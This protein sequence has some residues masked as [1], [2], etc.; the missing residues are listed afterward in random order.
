MSL[1]QHV[2]KINAD[3]KLLE[4]MI[5][6]TVEATHSAHKAKYRLDL[7]SEVAGQRDGGVKE[8]DIVLSVLDGTIKPF[9][10]TRVENG[11]AVARNPKDG[12][13]IKFN[14]DF[15]TAGAYSGLQPV[16]KATQRLEQKYPNSTVW[17]HGDKSAKNDPDSGKQSRKRVVAT[18]PEYDDQGHIKFEPQPE[19]RGMGGQNRDSGTGI[20]N[21]N[22]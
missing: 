7:I 16:K 8:R 22:R 14:A 3:E 9:V 2:S 19:F 17:V 18:N 4:D 15:V 5:V 10:V 11:L 12:D 21:R 20:A 13:E 6:E 1:M